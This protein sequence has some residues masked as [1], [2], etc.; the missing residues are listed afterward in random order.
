ME[1][2]LVYIKTDCS[3]C[4]NKKH[5]K[6]PL[7]HFKARYYVP[8]SQTNENKHGLLGLSLIGLIL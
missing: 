1:S 2:P 4:N 7:Q 5:K 8:T 6:A 3:I